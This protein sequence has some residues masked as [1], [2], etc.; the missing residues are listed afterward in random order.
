MRIHEW[1][2]LQLLKNK[3]IEAAETKGLKL[4]D[5][6]FGSK[7]WNASKKRVFYLCKLE[8]NLFERPSPSTVLGTGAEAVRSSAA[9][10]YNLLGENE[11][12]LD[13]KTY[14]SIEYEKQ[15]PAIKDE[16][17]KKHN[18]HLDAVFLSSDKS[19][20]YA[21]EAKLLE[22][23]DSPKNLAAAYLKKAM[24]F[25]ANTESKVFIDFFKS[26]ID[27]KLD[28][29]G[30][31]KHNKKR[32]DA[33]QMIIH[34]LG[35]YNHF[36]EMKTPQVKKLTLLNVVW[37]YECDEYEIE[38]NEAAQ[39]LDDANNVF[40]PLFKRIGIDFSI[41]Y[42]TFQAFKDKL[43]FA[44]DSNRLEYLKRYLV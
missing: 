16:G 31:Y 19:E 8:N 9:M 2:V 11:L 36:A 21:I 23:K 22:W 18:A 34:T 26:L 17:S 3:L 42:S 25:P 33:I 37:K 38:E 28:A 29:N 41:Q 32:Y 14:S 35:L 10:I 6:D 15:F 1:D 20:M 44:K 43:T 27:L 7:R 4:T 5:C 13:G 12:V 30:R 39:F 40:S 24:Y